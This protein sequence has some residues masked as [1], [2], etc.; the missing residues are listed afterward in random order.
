M[1]IEEQFDEGH[2]WGVYATLRVFIRRRDGYINATKLCA[3]E[4]R[5]F[6]KWLRDGVP[7]MF[8][9]LSLQERDILFN[10]VAVGYCSAIHGTYI[11]PMLVPVLIEWI[12]PAFRGKYFHQYTPDTVWWTWPLGYGM[13]AADTINERVVLE[14][15]R[16]K[17]ASMNSRGNILS[18]IT[19]P[20][21]VLCENDTFCGI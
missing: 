11:H 18:N 21:E 15:N 13:W 6:G 1:L 4:G 7:K 10:I 3:S 20:R 19:S 16:R 8:L 12:L 2:G 14:Y 5:D 9:N 17:K